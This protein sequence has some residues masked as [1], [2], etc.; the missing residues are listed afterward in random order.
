[1][2]IY[3]IIN[4]ALLFLY[5]SCNVVEESSMKLC[6]CFDT[7]REKN[8]L[9]EKLKENDRL[10]PDGLWMGYESRLGEHIKIGTSKQRGVMY[11]Y[12]YNYEKGFEV[13]VNHSSL[14][15]S[16]LPISR[17]SI[18]SILDY[19]Y[20]NCIVNFVEQ[21]E[22]TTVGIYNPQIDSCT[23]PSASYYRVGVVRNLENDFFTRINKKKTVEFVN[24]SIFI[25][26]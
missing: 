18:Q 7:E 20:R 12:R 17:D 14:T 8:N 19:C 4:I 6:D 11:I 24:D 5:I 3:R 23:F 22:V 9:L 25:V 15:L 10:F 13:D 16:D 26:R 21:D 2:K 1:M